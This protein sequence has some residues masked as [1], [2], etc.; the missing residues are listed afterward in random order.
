MV[1]LVRTGMPIV[2]MAMVAGISSAATPKQIDDAIKRGTTALKAKYSQRNAGPAPLMPD[3]GNGI[4]PSCMAALAMMEGGVPSNDPAMKTVTEQI[5]NASYTQ[6]RTYQVSLCLIFLDRLG[7]PA[8]EPMIQILGLRLLAGQKPSGGWGYDC[9]S[10]EQVGNLQWLK[11]IKPIKQGATP[12]LCPEAK[13]YAQSLTGGGR[14]GGPTDDNSNTQFAVIAAWLARKHGVRDDNAMDLIERRFMSTQN[15]VNF[16]WPYAGTGEGSPAMYCAGLIGMSTALARREERK[17][18]AEAKKE[19]KQDPAAPP[20]KVS[21][22]PFFNPAPKPNAEPKKEKRTFDERDRVVANAFAGLGQILAQSAQAGGGALILQEGKHGHNDLY[23]MWSLERTCVIYG[24][25]KVGGV[26]W[27]E[28]GAHS[29]V[30]KQGADGTWPSD[31]YGPE[32]STAFAV[33]FLCRSNLARDLSGKVQK[34]TAT[35]MRAGAGPA[36]TEVRPGE[37]GTASNTPEIPGLPGVG[38]SDA[39][40]LASS[41]VR[42]T[43]KDWA[44]V[45]KKLRESR[46]GNYTLALVNAANRLEGDRLKQTRDALAER[47]TRMTADTLRSMAKSEEPELRR[48]ALLA[49]AMKDEKK[50]IPDLIEAVS[51]DEEIVVRA[52]R[53]G[54][55][56]LTDQDFGPPKDAN[57]GEKTLAKDAWK[58]WWEKQKK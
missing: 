55:R 10:N 38:G 32:V 50:H 34:E 44:A 26:D 31:G 17:A 1:A 52:A 29:L 23:F 39:A 42:S 2:F 33:L 47:L 53:A 6:S 19:P 45:L 37:A 11:S 16:N 5:R 46:G 13:Q 35:E 4:G 14:A 18:K 27:Y 3:T 22:D 56:S 12:E 24:K 30:M 57:V 36:G 48:A 21:D 41:L 43:E 25:E 40:V 54:L 9:I 15:P 20:K 8:D 51:D 58:Q 7:D 49:M 28:A